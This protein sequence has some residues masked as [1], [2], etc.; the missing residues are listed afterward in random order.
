MHGSYG[1]E[2]PHGVGQEQWSPLLMK[3]R[4]ST[5]TQPRRPVAKE[6]E[7]PSAA[8]QADAAKLK[9]ALAMHQQGQLNQAEAMYKEILLSQ[10]QHFVALQLLATIAVQRKNSALA[11][12]LF[13]RALKIKPDYAVALNNRGSALVELKR[14]DD[15]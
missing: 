4:R 5:I 15:A 12:E 10:P 14:L 9:T 7:Q 2:D 3:R 13:D 8:A 11:V 6:S 1:D